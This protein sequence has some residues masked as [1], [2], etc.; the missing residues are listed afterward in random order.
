MRKSMG[1]VGLEL[2]PF[3]EIDQVELN[4]LRAVEQAEIADQRVQQGRFTRTGLAGNEDVLSRSLT[5]LQVLPPG[6]AHPPQ[7]DADARPAIGGPPLFWRRRDELKR[8]FH[9]LGSASLV[10]DNLQNA[11]AQL[12]GWGGVDLQGKSLEIGVLPQEAVLV[13]H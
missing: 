7:G 1:G 3:L 11:V 13:P 10:A 9:A 12:R 8:H 2:D 4:F 6:G 5:Q